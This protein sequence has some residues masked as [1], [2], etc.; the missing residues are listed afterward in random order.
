ML[1]STPPPIPSLCALS[2][3]DPIFSIP[4]SFFFLSSFTDV[5]FGFLKIKFYGWEW[6]DG[7]EIGVVW[8]G[9][10]KAEGLVLSFL[11]FS[12]EKLKKKNEEE[13]EMEGLVIASNILFFRPEGLVLAIFFIFFQLFL[14]LG[15]VGMVWDCRDGRAGCDGEGIDLER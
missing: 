14:L 15:K 6:C 1:L 8:C 7:E 5:K 13:E 4:L 3:A 2:T 10:M 11:S 9:V 12:S